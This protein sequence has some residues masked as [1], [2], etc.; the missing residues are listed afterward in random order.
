MWQRMALLGISGECQGEKEGEHPHGGRGGR[1]RG[2]LEGRPGEG[3]IF[4]MIIKKISNKRK[5]KPQT[6]GA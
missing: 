1:D 5:K 3:I 6:P 4:E 2:F